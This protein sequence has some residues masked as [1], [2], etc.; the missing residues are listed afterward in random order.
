[1]LGDDRTVAGVVV[2]GTL[3]GTPGAGMATMA[4]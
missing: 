3:V 4:P 1:M 2:N